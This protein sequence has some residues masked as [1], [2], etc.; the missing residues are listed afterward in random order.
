MNC[1]VCG[2][3]INETPYL[4]LHEWSYDDYGEMMGTRDYY[5]DNRCLEVAIK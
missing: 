2:K 3:I 4:E 5:C 1:S